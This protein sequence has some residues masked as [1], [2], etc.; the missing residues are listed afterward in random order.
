MTNLNTKHNADLVI[1]AAIGGYVVWASGDVIANVTLGG[2][3]LL[4][5]GA[6]AQ[7]LSVY[8]AE[9]GQFECGTLDQLINQ[10]KEA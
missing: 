2:L 1:T 6:S 3:N 8:N 10:S 5:A 7:G 9:T 4:V